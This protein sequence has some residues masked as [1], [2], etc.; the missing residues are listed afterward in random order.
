MH[1]SLESETL[2][3]RFD[4][5]RFP[6]IILVIYIH[7]ASIQ[8]TANGQALSVSSSPFNE[9]VIYFFSQGIARCAV[10]LFYLMAGYLFFYRGTQPSRGRWDKLRSRIYSLLIPYLIWNTL[11]LLLFLAGQSLPATASWFSGSHA[12]LLSMNPAELGCEII[13]CRQYPIAYQFWFIR[14]LMILIVFSVLI[15]EWLRP[16]LWVLVPLSFLAWLFQY[17]P[18][19]MPSCEATLFFLIGAGMAR[20]RI[21]PFAL[22]PWR[23]PA[24]VLAVVAFALSTGLRDAPVSWLLHVVATLAGLVAA[25]SLSARTGPIGT[26]MLSLAPTSFFLFAV[27]EPTLQVLRKIGLRLFAA[28]PAGA[29]AVYIL[30]PVAVAAL[31]LA[32]FALLQRTLPRMLAILVGKA[33]RRPVVPGFACGSEAADSSGTT[34]S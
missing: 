34:Q 30:A 23:W 4:T 9:S 24:V 28:T 19:L 32:L 6:L 22:D 1:S 13:G 15:G 7:N 11:V 31:G 26:A 18:V 20:Y 8:A 2:Y 29:L 16:A 25:L 21:S 12:G 14:D 17:W 27:H 3:R 10:P 33:A 5:L